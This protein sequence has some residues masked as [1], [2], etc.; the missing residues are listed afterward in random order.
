MTEAG[1][2]TDRALQAARAIIDRRD[3]AKDFGAI[4]VTAEHAI[5]TLLIA[6]MGGNPRKAAAMLNE[7]LVEGVENRLSLYMAEDQPHD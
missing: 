6:L 1:K 3:V 7:G 5:A 2:D 4:M